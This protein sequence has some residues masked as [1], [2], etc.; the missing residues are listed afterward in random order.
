MYQNSK[1]ST[2]IS[3][4]FCV[5]LYLTSPQNNINNNNK[6]IIAQSDFIFFPSVLIT[7]LFVFIFPF[8]KA[9]TYHHFLNLVFS[10][11]FIIMVLFW[12]LAYFL[13]SFSPS[14][15]EVC[16]VL[17]ALTKLTCNFFA[18]QHLLL[19]IIICYHISHTYHTLAPWYSTST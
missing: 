11:H 15:N 19:L 18:Q 4:Y 5:S 10:S 1:H 17:T 16:M 12:Y 7:Y 8:F 14:V 9:T 6:I 2:W 13:H 3:N